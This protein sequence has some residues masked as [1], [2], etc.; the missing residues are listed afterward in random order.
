MGD[1]D[2]AFAAMGDAPAVAREVLGAEHVG[3][4]ITEAK[5]ARIEVA[6]GAPAAEAAL[7]AVVARMAAALGAE[8]PQT[9]KYAALV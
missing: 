3:T 7:R 9:R 6:R 5:A 1:L 4:L 2:A 8:H